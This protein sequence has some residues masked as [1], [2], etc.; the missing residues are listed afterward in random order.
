MANRK[1]IH[2]QKKIIEKIAWKPGEKEF[3]NQ[4]N[5]EWNRK[6]IVVCNCGTVAT[7]ASKKTHS[8]WGGEK[9]SSRRLHVKR[10]TGAN[11]SDSQVPPFM[12]SKHL[13]SRSRKPFY[14]IKYTKN[15]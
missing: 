11:G 7:K 13:L 3:C 14:K 9:E 2:Q 5:N 4:Q 8:N 1:N 10:K 12:H 15:T 6:F